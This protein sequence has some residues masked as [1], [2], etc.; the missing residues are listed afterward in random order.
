MAYIGRGI[1]NFSQIEVLDLI[2][3]TNSAGPYNITKD[4]VAFV[5]STVNS[6]LI[7]VDGIIQ[8]PASYTISGSTITFGASMPSTSTMNSMI[9]FGTGLITTPADGSVTAAKIASD[10][11]TTAKILDNNVTVAKLP[12]TLDISGNTV[13]LPASVSGLGTG[14]TNAQ[15]AG[16]ID[17]T[18]K[19]TGVVPSANLGSGTGSSA[20]FLRGDSSWQ[21][22]ATG[23]SWQSVTTGATLTAV[24]GNGYPINT[25][26]NACT[27]TLPA[28]ASVGDT[29]EFVDYARTWGT[30]AVTINQN[31]LNFQGG[32]VT[33]PVYN[34]DGQSLTIVY[35]DATQGWIPTVDDEV[36]YETG[37]DHEYLVVGGGG[38]GGRD[39]S[40]TG[41]GGAGGAG[42]YRTNYG[43]T[44]LRLQN[45]ATY[46]ITVGTGGPV[47]GDPGTGAGAGAMGKDG[48]DSS[49]AGAKITTI[50]GTGGGGGA[51]GNSSPIAG[52]NPGGSGGGGNENASSGDGGAGNEGGDGGSPSIPEGF[53]GGNGHDGG[54]TGNK[55]AGGGGGAS[56]AGDTDGLGYGG[57][58]LANSITGSSVTYAGG[59]GGANYNSSGTYLPGGDGGGGAGASYNE[60]PAVDG[61][62]ELGGGGG[63]CADGASNSSRDPT[64]GG[65]GIVILRMADGDAGTPSGEDSISTD[66]GGSG[67]TVI[68]WIA[69]GSYVV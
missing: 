3:F 68:K 19:I 14:I 2:T 38:S 25:T 51:G 18:S 34:T 26:S 10:A 21:E 40:V 9:H 20:N 29:I 44:T 16:S 66:V 43:G 22:V 65:D 4:S 36:T 46:T 35:V 45:G 49:I 63:G 56:E 53:A 7:E 41:S 47:F 67:E 58:G 27:V 37:I 5:P 32:A 6:L 31:S 39:S 59:G 1:E 12:T 55:I 11:V 13:T 8:A 48:G 17:V 57:D 61:T 15:L 62:D 69:T 33:N 28:S 52:G 30:N 50:T 64:V 42:G 24:A 60:G 54:G 23:T